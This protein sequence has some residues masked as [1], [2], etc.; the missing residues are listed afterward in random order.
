MESWKWAEI[1]LSGG[2]CGRGGWVLILGSGGDGFLGFGIVRGVRGGAV[3]GGREGAVWR[4]GRKACWVC[5]CHFCECCAW[6]GGGSA[7]FA[8]LGEW[9][10]CEQDKEHAD[11]WRTV[12]GCGV[13]VGGS[14]SLEHL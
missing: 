6:S 5:L 11:W 8:W 1:G 3:Y 14:A 10:S 13:G 2:L 12:R 9:W 4:R 7:A